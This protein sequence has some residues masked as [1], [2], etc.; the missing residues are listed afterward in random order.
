MQLE[1]RMEQE[2]IAMVEQ[3]EARE[4]RVIGVIRFT[5][6]DVLNRYIGE[7][8]TRRAPEVIRLDIQRTLKELHGRFRHQG[9]LACSISYIALS[10]TVDPGYIVDIKFGYD[11]VEVSLVE[12]DWRT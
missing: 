8:A 6:N 9:L 1:D 10:I 7:M 4:H 12:T 3:R 11:D 2:A 5:I